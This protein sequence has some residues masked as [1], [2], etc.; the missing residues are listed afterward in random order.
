MKFN[1]HL[2]YKK[3]VKKEWHKKFKIN[4]DF[5]PKK[6][7]FVEDFEKASRTVENNINEG[8]TQYFRELSYFRDRI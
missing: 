1:N 5:T 7:I 2:K 6:L 3:Y 8:R 4:L